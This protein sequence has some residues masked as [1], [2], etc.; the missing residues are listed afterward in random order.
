[1]F[2]AAASTDHQP[3][4]LSEAKDL[5]AT[6]SLQHATAPTHPSSSPRAS[7]GRLIM[8][9]KTKEYVG[10]MVLSAAAVCQTSAR[11]PAF[12]EGP[13]VVIARDFYIQTWCIMCADRSSYTN[14][15]GRIRHPLA[16]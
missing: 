10:P 9:V 15:A 14:A 5:A 8:P 1:M 12:V 4:I 16:A 13:S 2:H 11:R 3:V 7:A 6:A